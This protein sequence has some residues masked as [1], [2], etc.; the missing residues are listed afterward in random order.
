M[1]VASLELPNG[2]APGYHR[3]IQLQLGI[4][5]WMVHVGRVLGLLTLNRGGP[6]FVFGRFLLLMLLLGDHLPLL[7]YFLLPLL[8]L[9]VRDE[10][11]VDY[12]RRR[13]GVSKQRLGP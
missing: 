4:P 11:Q 12:S 13:K 10:E 6:P 3:A 9:Q 7:S 2:E 8:L 5:S 1:G